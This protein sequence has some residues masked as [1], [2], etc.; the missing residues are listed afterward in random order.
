MK[1]FASFMQYLVCFHCSKTTHFG[2]KYLLVGIPSPQGSDAT[3]VARLHMLGDLV[4][5]V[6]VILAGVVVWI[7]PTYVAADSM[8]TFVYAGMVLVTT[9]NVLHDLVRTLM[10]RAPPEMDTGELFN[11]LA[12]IKG[13]ID[14]H[15][16]HVWMLG[17]EK[18]AMSAH[19]H[20]EDEEGMFLLTFANGGP[21]FCYYN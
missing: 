3:N 19:M 9:Y 17:P 18:I 14:V 7:E 11:E 15:C 16:C 21:V 8:T 13:V 4:Q 20:I 2:L 1:P 10:E 5:G 12:R 6:S